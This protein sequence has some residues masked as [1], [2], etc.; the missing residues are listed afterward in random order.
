M[1][2]LDGGIAALF[3]DVFGSL[4]L[5][6]VLERV[7]KSPDGEGGATTVTTTQPCKVQQ[8]RVTDAM[9][10][11]GGYTEND[12]RFLILQAG[13]IGPL[14]SDCRL[15]FEGV[16]YLLASPEQDPTRSYWACRATPQ[17]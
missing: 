8:D 16:R 6:A 2:L 4:Y 17:E 13:I 1:G 12:V 15:V 7:V 5:S 11:D 3:G 14:D 9:R 10:A